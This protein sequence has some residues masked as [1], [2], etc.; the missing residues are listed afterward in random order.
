[1]I[2]IKRV[3]VVKF[4]GILDQTINIDCRNFTVCGPNGT[5]KSGV[6]DAIEF[7][8]SGDISRLSGR[9]RG[10]VSVKEHAPHVDF[11][12][13]PDDA[14]VC[15]EGVVQD[16]GEAFS[17]TRT[18]GDWRNPTIKPKSASIDDAL[19][20]L[21]RNKN[22]TLSRR[23]LIQFVLSTPGDR[24]EEIQV[25]L[26]LNFLRET[27]KTLQK[28]S[29]GCARDLKILQGERNYAAKYLATSVGIPVVKSSD[30]LTKVNEKRKI[31]GLPDISKFEENTSVK[32]G[33]SV[34]TAA[35]KASLS[36][37]I[38]LSDIQELDD[39]LVGFTSPA[40]KVIMTDLIERLRLLRESGG[41][42]VGIDKQ[43]LFSR[44]LKLL[45]D[46]MCPVC[47]TEWKQDEL[48]ALIIAKLA[49]LEGI[50]KEKTDVEM[51]LV[52]IA[53][54]SSSLRLAINAVVRIGNTLNPKVPSSELTKFSESLLKAQ[55][56]MNQFES[57]DKVFPLLQSLHNHGAEFS[58]Q[59]ESIRAS[60]A[61]LPDTSERD[62]ARDY[63]VEVDVRLDAYRDAKRKEQKAEIEATTA[64][65][66]FE[67]FRRT[68]S[69]SLTKMYREIQNDFAELYREINKDDEAGFEASLPVERSGVGLDV[70][71][72]GRGK[73]PPGAYHSEGHQDGM[74][75]CLYLALMK[76]L[77]GEQFNFC[78]LDDVLMSVDSGH[79]RAVC[80]M[81]SKHFPHTQFLFTTHDEV[82]LKNMHSTG[83]VKSGDHLHFRNWSVEGGPSEW[84]A[85]EIWV[86]IDSL[87]YKHEI[88]A[89]SAKLR[90]YFEYL[91]GELCH[92]LGASVTYQGDHRYA[93]GQL[94][95]NATVR[96]GK[97]LK[98][99]KAAAN[100]WGNDEQLD[101]ISGKETLF[102][103]AV[104]TTKLEEW[105]VN[106]TVHFNS[107]A[108]LGKE[109]F[110]PIADAFKK[111]DEVF[112][113][114]KCSSLLFLRPHTGT[115]ETLRCA[116]DE[117][118]VNL[119]KKKPV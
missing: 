93:L 94:L 105:G 98:L 7:A 26:Q 106:A 79:R 35:K 16:T 47:D 49:E 59:L 1:M 8:L 40:S 64:Q 24:A 78:V 25:L 28:I 102:K 51:G 115:E 23:E 2:K 57:I 43:V 100:S 30:I 107:W 62:S 12:S 60:I 63:L 81:L 96:M 58:N 97:L 73:F 54:S 10:S 70:D 17:I 44:A 88:S 92:E 72:Y 69:D 5:G 36:K 108:S 82:W 52:P 103:E 19:D 80:A 83:L 85:S 46:D 6:V 65:Q 50:L 112:R 77:Y 3:R 34:A 29:N 48:K 84:T 87:I 91:S 119:K 95:P 118:H 31:L 89:A 18:V 14:F 90:H 42:E 117:T 104:M 39:Q 15:L 22:P 67:T 53:T 86:E 20:Q 75:L 74:G 27:Q 76:H 9:G 114:G 110:Q 33:L 113:C 99:G 111:L 71:F 11:R 101:K 55:S 13:R 116:C 32:D 61:S 45:D 68:Y 38:A 109:D 4:R 66:I 56:E 37:R 41:F 21:A